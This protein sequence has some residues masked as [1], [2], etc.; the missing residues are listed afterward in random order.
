MRTAARPG[1]WPQVA[2]PPPRPIFRSPPALS[3]SAPGAAFT[4]SAP[5]DRKRGTRAAGSAAPRLGSEAPLTAKGF[6]LGARTTALSARKQRGRQKGQ[7][8]LSPPRWAPAGVGGGSDRGH[9]AARTP[10][11]RRAT[12]PPRLSPPSTKRAVRDSSAGSA[13]RGREARLRQGT[14]FC[15]NGAAARFARSF[16]EGSPEKPD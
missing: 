7:E 1:P 12:G 9:R 6:H 5:I 14:G 3:K 16:R 8:P 13:G 11:P 2:G 4:Q 15:A 10:G